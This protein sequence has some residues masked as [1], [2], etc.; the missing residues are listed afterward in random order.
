MID[1]GHITSGDPAVDL[2][3]AWMLLPARWHGAFR[4]AYRAA[5]AG[6]GGVGVID[7]GMWVRARGWALSMAVGFLMHCAD[8]PQLF[9]V[10]RRTLRAVLAEMSGATPIPPPRKLSLPGS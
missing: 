9:G 8:N 6:V 1:F 5:S 10:G 7:D 4:E 3:V 2:S